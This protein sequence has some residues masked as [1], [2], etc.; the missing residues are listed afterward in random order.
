MFFWTSIWLFSLSVGSKPIKQRLSAP[1]SA[2]T[3]TELDLQRRIL[4]FQRTYTIEISFSTRCEFST[5]MLPGVFESAPVRVSSTCRKPL[6]GS[7]SCGFETNPELTISRFRAEFTVKPSD[8]NKMIW[9]PKS[10][11]KLHST[12]AGSIYS[13]PPS[14]CNRLHTAPPDAVATCEPVQGRIFLVDPGPYT[15]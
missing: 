10:F 4:P 15:H 7:L 3:M 6:Y 8:S 5:A 1:Q 2:P 14:F 12:P 13:P 9:V 11:F